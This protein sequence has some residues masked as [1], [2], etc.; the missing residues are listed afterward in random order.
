LLTLA[1]PRI[2]AANDRR[3]ARRIARFDE[4]C[5]PPARVRVVEHYFNLIKLIHCVAELST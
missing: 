5:S 2:N 3:H 1:A 4:K